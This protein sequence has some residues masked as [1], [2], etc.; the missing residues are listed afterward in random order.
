MLTIVTEIKD[1]SGNINRELETIK[2]KIGN[3][4]NSQL[5]EIKKCNN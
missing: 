2:G 3:Q 5:Q 1:N 4:K